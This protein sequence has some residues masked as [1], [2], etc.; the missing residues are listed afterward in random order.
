MNNK[1]GILYAL[2]GGA[3]WGFSGTCGQYVFSNSS[4]DAMTVTWLRLFISG[5]LMTL[6]GFF[7]D[8]DSILSL[9]KNK[10]D[11]IRCIIFAIVGL[12]TCQLSYLETIQYSNSGTATVFQYSGILIIMIVTCFLEKR[13]PYFK[14]LI[15][16][17]LVLVGVF[18]VA[19]HGHLSGLVVSDQALLWGSIAAFSLFLYTMLP[20]NLL[21]KYGA[22]NVLGIAMLI[23][24]VILTV[25]A[26]PWQMNQAITFPVVFGIA[27]IILFGTICGFSLYLSGVSKIG[28]MKASMIACVE[29]VVATIT[30]A[31]GLHTQFS[32]EDLIG[33]FFIIL[34]VLI[35]NY[36]KKQNEFQK[37]S[38]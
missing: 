18:F 22:I 14:D 1:K 24:G 38:S 13:L 16:V 30:S 36:Q 9:I 34:G 33:F 25:F 3:L 28:A 4:F 35:V 20:G 15:A 26:K 19:T 5:V 6:Y 31:L 8:R 29:P 37:E 32:G 2:L 12:L 21:N 11:C 23:D 10:K 7:V 17:I 27:S